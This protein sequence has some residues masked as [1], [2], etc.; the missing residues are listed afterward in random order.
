MQSTTLLITFAG[1]VSFLLVAVVFARIG[2]LDEAS[3]LGHLAIQLLKKYPA[4]QVET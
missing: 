2:E 1:S 3:R 4:K